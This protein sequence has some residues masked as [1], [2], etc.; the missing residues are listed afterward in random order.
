MIVVSELAFSDAG[1]APFNVGLLAVV[2]TAFPLDHL[3]FAGAPEHIRELKKQADEDLT[4]SIEWREIALLSPDVP[5]FI[6]LIRDM[7]ILQ[8]LLRIIPEGSQGLFLL[9]NAKTATLVALKL[10]KTFS[11]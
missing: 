2:R 6:R 1:H 11:I 4:K 5:Y 7:K 10:L 8:A 9:A 3:C